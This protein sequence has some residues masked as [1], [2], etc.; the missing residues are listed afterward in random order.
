MFKTF[1][2][3]FNE[4]DKER[5]PEPVFKDEPVFDDNGKKPNKPEKIKEEF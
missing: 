3:P 2:R 5:I 1:I 4:R